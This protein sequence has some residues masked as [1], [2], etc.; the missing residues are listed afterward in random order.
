MSHDPQQPQRPVE[1]SEQWDDDFIE[2][3]DD[4][5]P[6]EYDEWQDFYGGDDWDHGQY[7]HAEYEWDCDLHNEF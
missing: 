6:S 4:G 3:E 7:D 5:Q 1:Q 2:L